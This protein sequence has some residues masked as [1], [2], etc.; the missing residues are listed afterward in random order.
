M[1]KV[2]LFTFI[3][4]ALFFISQPVVAQSDRA[5]YKDNSRTQYRD[6][7]YHDNIKTVQLHQTGWKFSPPIIKLHSGQHLE[8]E[9]DDLDADY[10]SY[11]YTFIHCDA[12]WQPSDINNFDYLKG[13]EQDFVTDYSTSFNTSQAYTHYHISIPN[14]NIQL[15]IS[16][17]YLLKVYLNNNPDSVVLTRRFMVYEDKLRINARERPGVGSDLFTKQEV[18]FSINTVQY[19]ILDPFHALQVYILQNSRWDNAIT[20]VQPQFITDTALQYYSDFGN[21]FD[22]GNQ[23]RNIDLTSVKFISEHMAKLVPNLD[24]PEVDLKHDKLR[25]KD[26][27]ST[28]PDI[29]GQYLIQTKDADS[30]TINS[31]YVAVHFHLDMDTAFTTG[32]VYIFGQISDWQCKRELQMRFVDS[33]KEYVADVYLK[34]G[35]Y[36][37]QYAFLPDHSKVADCTVIEGSHSETENTYTIYAYYRPVGIYYDMLIGVTTFHAPSN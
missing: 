11:Y 18:V 24:Y 19:P 3:F 26:Q 14:K 13:F 32:N 2:S 30:S 5:T 28:I 27:F 29:D 31:E 16:G 37:Y 9:F 4:P 36:D 17:N 23:F 21:E 25:T 6:R 10:K 35:Y 22:G 8:L 33:L 12:D 34:Q 7:V 20:N 15:L 1:R